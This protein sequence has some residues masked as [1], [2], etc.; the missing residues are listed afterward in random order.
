MLDAKWLVSEKKT[1][2]IKNLTYIKRAYEERAS[3]CAVRTYPQTNMSS[4][5]AEET[6][7]MLTM[8]LM[9]R[10]ATGLVP[11]TTLILITH[12]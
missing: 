5:Y 8:F 12:H 6:R 4:G 7:R 11:S 3:A 9:V 1:S 10:P 2:I